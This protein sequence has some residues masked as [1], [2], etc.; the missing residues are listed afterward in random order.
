MFL[1]GHEA[2][3]TVAKTLEALQLPYDAEMVLVDMPIG[4]TDDAVHR[5]VETEV[6]TLLSPH[7][8]SSVFP[9]PCR[10]A[11]Y[12][13][14]WEAACKAN[15]NNPKLNCGVNKQTFGICRKI[16]ELDVF[17]R[18]HPEWVPRVREAHPELCFAG[19]NAE[20]GGPLALESKKKDALGQDDRLALL[21]AHLPTAASIYEKM[22][23]NT[24]HKQ[25]QRDDAIDALCL[26]VTAQLGSLNGF[27]RVPRQTAIDAYQLPIELLYV[28]ANTL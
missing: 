17:L 11:V 24:L 12:A 4:L 13:S 18:A 10:E 20:S 14:S 19:L 7:K 15:E 25:V 5:E 9:V 16:K 22:V 21:Q 23:R 26:A 6:R 28:N 3:F 27:E 1:R 8:T 2:T